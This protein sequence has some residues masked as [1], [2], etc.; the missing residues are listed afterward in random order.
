MMYLGGFIFAMWLATR[1]ASRPCSGWTKNEVENFL[2][3]GF[4]CVFLGGR[5]GY[6]LFYNF[7]QFMAEPLYLF[8]VWDG[9]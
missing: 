5:I 8:R 1:R 3:A 2:Y 4:L 7:P 6:F 9:G